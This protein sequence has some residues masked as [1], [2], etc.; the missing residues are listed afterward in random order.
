MT[1]LVTHNMKTFMNVAY[2]RQR[3][4]SMRQI[5]SFLEQHERYSLLSRRPDG[6]HS[7]LTG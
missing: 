6:S 2:I 4:E 3:P 1:Q 5:K 7:A